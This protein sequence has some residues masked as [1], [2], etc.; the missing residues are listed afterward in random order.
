SMIVKELSLSFSFLR[1]FSFSLCFIRLTYSWAALLAGLLLP[2]KL[3]KLCMALH[4]C[5]LL[6]S[7]ASWE[8]RGKR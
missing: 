3:A 8:R 4:L 1:S 5:P 6:A 7:F 2:E